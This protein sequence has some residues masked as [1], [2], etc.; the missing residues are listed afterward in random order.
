MLTVAGAV[1]LTVAGAVVQVADARGGLAREAQRYQ[2]AEAE[3]A[4]AAA[5]EME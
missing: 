1:V 3:E 4:R 2:Q 5:S